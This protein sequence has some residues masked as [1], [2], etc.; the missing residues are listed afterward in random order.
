MR[1]SQLKLVAR[2]KPTRTDM[3]TAAKH[4]KVLTRLDKLAGFIAFL[5]LAQKAVSV[6]V[7]GIKCR[8]KQVGG[9]DHDVRAAG[10]DLAIGKLGVFQ[11]YTFKA[12]WSSEVSIAFRCDSLPGLHLPSAA[13]RR[14]DSFITLSSKTMP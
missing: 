14:C 10:K 3:A 1:H 2:K 7:L 11:G 9:I 6:K 4:I 12:D 13:E 5:P 8:V